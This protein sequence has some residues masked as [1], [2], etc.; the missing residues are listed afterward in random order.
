[1]KTNL[2]RFALN[3]LEA[4]N[5]VRSS[6]LKSF[7]TTLGVIFGV[8]SVISMLAI[9][10]GTQKEILD[11]L[12][13][14][15]TNNIVIKS[16]SIIYDNVNS[17]MGMVSDSPGLS[18]KDSDNF[19]FV[20]SISLISP[21]IILEKEAINNG[22]IRT[23]KLVGVR[24][25]YFDLYNIKI[26]IGQEFNK[27]HLEQGSPVC[28]LGSNIRKAFYPF[29]NPIGKKIKL[30]DN[31]LTIIGVLENLIA[32]ERYYKNLDIRNIND[33]VYIPLQTALIRYRN[34]EII[35]ESHLV[36]IQSENL[37]PKGIVSTQN[38]NKTIIEHQIDKVVLMVSK[39]EFLEPTANIISRILQRRHLN[40]KDYEIE[41]P[42]ILIK[43][44]Q[45]TARILNYV[46]GIIA[47]ISLLVGGI[48]IMNIMLATVLERTNEIGV[49]LASGARASDIIQQFLSESVI[50][51]LVGGVL[52]IIVGLFICKTIT[53]LTSI[54]TI[55]TF[56]NVLLSFL[57]SA[58]VGVIFGFMPAYRA[59]KQNPIIS[60][61][62]E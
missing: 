20:N 33:D 14:V 11:Q 2:S 39:S 53:Y 40:V 55:I 37:P 44:Q 1:M 36:K 41:I 35:N 17:N 31:W 16:K 19:T 6:K 7:L 8:A 50:L 43:A 60:L 54:S 4:I 34:T 9:G 5:A 62:Y 61:H 58:V 48:G 59:S 21:E 52:G 22:S 23:T 32:D 10:A 15:G 29:E 12:R 42:E 47:G 57:V 56:N 18:L 27:F 25:T 30:G 51:C 38:D 46:L 24:N 49:R 3:A 13:L 28:I 26:E 45:R